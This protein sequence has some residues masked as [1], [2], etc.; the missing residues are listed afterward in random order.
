[1]PT[2]SQSLGSIQQQK[3]S[4]DKYVSAGPVRGGQRRPTAATGKHC[5]HCM[6]GSTIDLPGEQPMQSLPHDAVTFSG[7]RGR[8][9]CPGPSKVRAAGQDSP[10]ACSLVGWRGIV[11]AGRLWVVVDAL[12]HH[13]LL[14]SSR[15]CGM[16]AQVSSS[17]QDT[18]LV[19]CGLAQGRCLGRASY[20]PWLQK[21]GAGAT[22]TCAGALRP[23]SGEL[24]Q[25]NFIHLHSYS[26]L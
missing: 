18:L 7:E 16:S 25:R 20:L 10:G 23:A 21:A 19:E 12:Q 6:L 13:P 15:K 11:G 26:A 8:C 3:A 4:Q 2:G 24:C 22:F 9:A 5:V 14:S 17:H 1:M